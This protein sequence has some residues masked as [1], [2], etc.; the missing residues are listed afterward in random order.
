MTNSINPVI[1]LTTQHC[2]ESI[3]YEYLPQ[4]QI[5]RILPNSLNTYPELLS[6]ERL[7]NLIAL[8]DTHMEFHQSYLHIPSYEV[9]SKNTGEII[10]DLNDTPQHN[11]KPIHPLAKRYNL[12]SYQTMLLFDYKLL[13]EP[14]HRD[15]ALYAYQLSLEANNQ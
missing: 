9:I 13:A 5:W 6:S 2:T 14:N 15:L 1:I 10:L 7:Y 4:F 11:P 3:A 8:E 12:D